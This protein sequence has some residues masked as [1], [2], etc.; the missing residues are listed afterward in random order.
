[1]FP[2]L[3]FKQTLM[4]SFFSFWLWIIALKFW[5]D[6]QYYSAWWKLVS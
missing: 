5:S 6:R 2:V 1:M 4:T 3:L